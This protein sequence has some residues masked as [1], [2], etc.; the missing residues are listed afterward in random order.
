MK[1]EEY[2]KK[3]TKLLE[4]YIDDVQGLYTVE[5]DPYMNRTDEVIVELMKLKQKA[6]VK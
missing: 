6:G 4:N 3:V 1:I 5:T 2:A